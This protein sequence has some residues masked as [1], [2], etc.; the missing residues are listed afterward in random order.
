MAFKIVSLAGDQALNQDPQ[1][2]T[3]HGTPNSSWL[4]EAV[5]AVVD[6]SPMAGIHMR[7]KL[8]YTG[9]AKDAQWD[10]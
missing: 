4:A 6:P 10:K 9:V 5:L 2:D 3:S 7:G 8:G 1:G